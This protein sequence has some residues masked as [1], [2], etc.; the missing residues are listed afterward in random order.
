MKPLSKIGEHAHFCSS[1]SH[2]R[3]NGWWNHKGP[4]AKPTEYACKQHDKR[5]RTP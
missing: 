3:H 4:C 1:C 2:Q 5:R